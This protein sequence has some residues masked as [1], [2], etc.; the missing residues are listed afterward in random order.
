MIYKAND[1]VTATRIA[2]KLELTETLFFDVM[3]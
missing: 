1:S 2:T 3:L